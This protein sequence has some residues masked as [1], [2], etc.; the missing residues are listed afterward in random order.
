MQ[1]GIP[2]AHSTFCGVSPLPAM[3]EPSDFEAYHVDWNADDVNI[4]PK[5]AAEGAQPS[6]SRTPVRLNVDDPDD[7]EVNRKLQMSPS[8][9]P[10][11]FW[12]PR[13]YRHSD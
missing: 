13:T 10:A 9:R 2:G 8:V 5:S 11:A 4:V 12:L 3:I 7:E 6:L 1:P